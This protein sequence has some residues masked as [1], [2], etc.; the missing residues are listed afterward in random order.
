MERQQNLTAGALL[1]EERAQ[2]DSF[3]ICADL[4][5]FSSKMASPSALKTLACDALHLSDKLCRV[6]GFEGVE[7]LTDDLAANRGP[8]EA[9][10]SPRGFGCRA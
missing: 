7:L 1:R 2:R 6:I 3:T 5:D 4:P 8:I 9:P 10:A